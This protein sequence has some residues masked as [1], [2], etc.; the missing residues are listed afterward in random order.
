M[1]QVK[2]RNLLIWILLT[3]LLTGTIDA[4]FAIIISYKIPA[5]TIFKFI[6]SGVFGMA[7][8][9]PNTEMIYYGILFHYCIAFAWAT[10]FFLLYD[11]LI[12]TVKVRSVLILMIGLIIWIIMNLV[13]V[14]LSHTPPQPFRWAGVI[15]NLIVLM[16]AFGLPV[17]LIADK[18][19][20]TPL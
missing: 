1:E 16:L 9:G 11:K 12:N 8:F 13:I 2:N 4:L 18:Y 5:A 20:N 14:P 10:I 15:E 17:T 6:A 7:A 19:Y 3:G